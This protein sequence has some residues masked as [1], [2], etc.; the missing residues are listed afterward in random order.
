MKF[1][2]REHKVSRLPLTLTLSPAEREQPLAIL[3]KFVSRE[4]EDRRG[5]AKN[6]GA[7]LPLPWGEGQGE[8]ERVANL[9]FNHTAAI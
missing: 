5:F 9:I 3:L 6:L 1:F 2:R 8:G 7:F 4:A